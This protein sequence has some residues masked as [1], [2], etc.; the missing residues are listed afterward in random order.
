MLLTSLFDP[1]PIF[2]IRIEF[3]DTGSI[4]VANITPHTTGEVLLANFLSCALPL[5]T[6]A[7]KLVYHDKDVQ[8]D[9]TLE[10]L[11]I[12]VDILLLIIV[13]L[14]YTGEQTNISK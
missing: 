6:G 12:K 10:G 1:V 8:P 14:Y 13:L 4:Y 3:P 7:F 5:E 11:G 9:D 2:P